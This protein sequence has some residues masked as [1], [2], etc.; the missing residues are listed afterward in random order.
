MGVLGLIAG[1]G[2][3]P[4]EVA[5]ACERA[6]RPVFV[7]RLKGMAD[8]A[9]QAFAGADVGLVEF[10]R[11]L[12]ALRGAGCDRVAF[13]GY[14][15][16]PD[17]AALKPD[18]KALK[19]LPGVVAA[20]RHGDDALLRAILAVFEKEGFAIDSLQDVAARLV[21]GPGP[22]GTV[23][24]RSEDQGDIDRALGAARAIGAMDIGQAAVACNGVVLAVEAQEGTDA[25]LGRCAGLPGVL[26]GSP[27]HR[28]GVLAKTPKPGQDRRIDLPTIGVATI[29]R[30]AEAGLAGIVGV[31]GAL[32]VVDAEGVRDTADRLGL[33]VLGVEAE[34]S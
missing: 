19:H 33:F 20:A 4:I 14:V 32:L 15:P 16:R 9:L 3:L 17:F 8:A 22:F 11:C 10:G 30:A 23:R 5:R 1:G 25:M 21:L 6:G 27:D 31:A 12:K 7:I 34:P 26:R 29:E 13:S 18:L 24:P 28:R 2:A